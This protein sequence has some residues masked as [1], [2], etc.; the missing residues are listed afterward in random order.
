MSCYQEVTYFV[1]CLLLFFLMEMGL[2]RK[3]EGPAKKMRQVVKISYLT[4]EIVAFG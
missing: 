1:F 3:A 2:R 4:I